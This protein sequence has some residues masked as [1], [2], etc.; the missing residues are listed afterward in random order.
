M[1]E[2]TI[3]QTEQQEDFQYL[4]DEEFDQELND[5]YETFQRL[6]Q[7]LIPELDA[8]LKQLMK[9]GKENMD[10]RSYMLIIYME[11]VKYKQ[12]ENKN[13]A[14]FCAMRLLWMKECMK[15]LRKKRP[16]YLDM[17]PFDIP[18]HMDSFIDETTGFL[19]DVYTNM[20]RKLR[21]LTLFLFL[22]V[23]GILVFALHVTFLFGAIEA[24]LIGSLNYMVQKRRLPDM[25][26]KNQTN[27][28]ERYV[29]EDV[30]SFDR[31]YRI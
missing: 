29:E 18:A 2:T 7:R 16:R 21:I 17:S 6:D 24:V 5:I 1:D 15:N 23:F 19:N 14:C 25:F 31:M 26:Q 9:L 4:N 28:V 30:L 22:V 3:T 12:E 11:G 10:V 13:A 8:R 27:A 20:N